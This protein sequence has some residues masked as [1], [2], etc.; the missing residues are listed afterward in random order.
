MRTMKFSII[1][2]PYSEGFDTYR[3]LITNRLY[4]ILLN[5][6]WSQQLHNVPQLI[7][8]Y[9][10]ELLS[11]GRNRLI[12]CYDYYWPGLTFSVMAFT[13]FAAWH[14]VAGAV[15]GSIKNGRRWLLV[16][17]TIS[18]V[19]EKYTEKP[20]R[21]MTSSGQ[22]PILPAI[23]QGVQMQIHPGRTNLDQK[24]VVLVFPNLLAEYL[25]M[26]LEV[27]LVFFFQNCLPRL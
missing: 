4:E 22:S 2:M 13:I 12:C 6:Q 17:N 8:K 3:S 21:S 14:T 10:L 26:I 1:L 19:L 7:W 24:L 25:S 27:C 23:S 18:E 9:P 20:I 5:G 16:L 11:E 15:T